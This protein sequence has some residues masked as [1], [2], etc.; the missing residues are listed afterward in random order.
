VAT[1]VVDA[2]LLVAVNNVL[3][4]DLLPF[5][6][7]DFTELVPLLNLSLVATMVANA[8]YI[9]FDP[10]WFRSPCQIVLDLISIAVAVRTWTVFPFDF[11][12]YSFDWEVVV[13]IVLALAIFGSGVAIITEV[14]KLAGAGRGRP[15]ATEAADRQ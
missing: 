14:V 5:L 12:A 6:T 7:D 11:T 2:L 3:E 10:I 4:W 13:R 9:W 8:V 15:S 1:I